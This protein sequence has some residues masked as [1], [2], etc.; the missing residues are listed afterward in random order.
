LRYASAEA[1]GS[2]ASVTNTGG[3]PPSRS[4][5]MRASRI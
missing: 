4:S 2:E 3:R 1:F 5:F